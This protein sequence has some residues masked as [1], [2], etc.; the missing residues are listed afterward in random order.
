MG[1]PKCASTWLQRLVLPTSGLPFGVP[2]WVGSKESDKILTGVADALSSQEPLG[3]RHHG[4]LAR[5]AGGAVISSELIACGALR[6][7]NLLP[8]GARVERLAQAAVGCDLKVL[9]IIRR[10]GASLLRA[11]HSEYV[12]LGGTRTG[13]AFVSNVANPELA[14]PD[15]VASEFASAFE[16]TTVLHLEDLRSNPDSFMAALASWLGVTLNHEI[17]EMPINPSLSPRRLA[18]ARMIN[19]IQPGYGE[20]GLLSGAP[21]AVRTVGTNVRQWAVRRLAP[22]SG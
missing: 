13:L 19:R 22:S 5:S 12:K 11:L 9:M 18:L 10:D 2:S 14:E 1:L 7:V 16:E 20:T 4:V 21:A 15:R 17:A 8:V 6:S 3:R